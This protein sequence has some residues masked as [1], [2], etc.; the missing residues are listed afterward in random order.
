MSDVHIVVA[1]RPAPWVDD[2][3]RTFARRGARVSVVDTGADLLDLLALSPD[4]VIGSLDILAP[5]PVH[6]LAMVRTVGFDVPFVVVLPHD[7]SSTRTH[8]ART[9]AAAGLTS[10]VD[11]S[12]AV[13]AALGMLAA[14][15][16]EGL[17]PMHELRAPRVC[18][19]GTILLAE[20]DTP[21][22]ELIAEELAS[23][24]HRVIEARDGGELVGLLHRWLG[25]ARGDDS[26][27]TS[28][29]DLVISD[30]RMPG[31]TGLDALAYVRGAR[32][33]VPFILMTSFGDD[34]MHSEGHRLG[35]L[36]VFDKPLEV[37][38]LLD[39]VDGVIEDA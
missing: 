26:R 17:V 9:A 3:Q 14:S 1:S 12:R 30:I 27:A 23:R 20:D 11:E 18:G 21:M 4:L 6:A 29:L 10:I 25:A 5:T 8:V 36:A 24:G 2:V 31:A 22:R 7:G 28:S 37:D 34:G 33:A 19:R 15:T 35:A 38:E 13:P 39:T 16:L 32:G